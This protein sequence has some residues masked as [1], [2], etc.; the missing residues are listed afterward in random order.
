MVEVLWSNNSL[1]Q[2]SSQGAGWRED[3]M[4]VGLQRDKV[5]E[6]DIGV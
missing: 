5:L 6:P 1:S 3:M 4:N 2:V